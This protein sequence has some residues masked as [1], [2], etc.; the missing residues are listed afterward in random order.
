MARRQLLALAG[1]LMR[2]IEFDS[3]RGAEMNP[4]K[5]LKSRALATFGLGK[6]ILDAGSQAV[7]RL[8]LKCIKGSI[9][10]VRQQK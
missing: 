1:T 10:S 8:R 6:N 7:N 3:S 5:T 2:H 4:G 9:F